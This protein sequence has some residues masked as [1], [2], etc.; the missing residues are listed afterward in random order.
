MS[1]IKQPSRRPTRKVAAAIIATFVVNGSI[2]VADLALPGFKELVP[3]E[4]W[5]AGVAVLL[6][7]YFTHERSNANQG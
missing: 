6:T 7:M 3:A 5:I 4:E 2:S 1:L